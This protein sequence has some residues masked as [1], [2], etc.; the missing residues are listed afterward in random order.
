MHP[1]QVVLDPIIQKLVDTFGAK[2]V[3]SKLQAGAKTAVTDLAEKTPTK[4]SASAR[5][6]SQSSEEG[7]SEA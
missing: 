5:R 7:T 3:Y 2:V 6:V 1:N 4:L